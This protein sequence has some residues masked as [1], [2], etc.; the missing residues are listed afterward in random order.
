MYEKCSEISLHACFYTFW[1]IPSVLAVQRLNIRPLARP[2]A[3]G[4]LSSCVAVP[5]DL[6]GPIVG[7]WNFV[8]GAAE[9][10]YFSAFGVSISTVFPI[11]L[12]QHLWCGFGTGVLV[13]LMIWS[14]GPARHNEFGCISLAWWQQVLIGTLGIPVGFAIGFGGNRLCT[15]LGGSPAFL[16]LGELLAAMLA[17]LWGRVTQHS[18]PL[19]DRRRDVAWCIAPIGFSAFVIAQALQTQLT[20]ARVQSPTPSEEIALGSDQVVNSVKFMAAWFVLLCIAYYHAFLSLPSHEAPL[21]VARGGGE[22]KDD[23]L[24]LDV[25]LVRDAQD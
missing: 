2:F 4:L 10:E 9:R 23:A 13:E 8:Q 1:V 14:T 7:W 12:A 20:G 15:Q 18:S 24:S 16:Y 6:A 3:V 19:S 5:F 17:V 21:D 22:T 11:A 25:P